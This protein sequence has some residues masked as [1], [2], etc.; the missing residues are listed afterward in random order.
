LEK[1]LAN[2]SF[3]IGRGRKKVRGILDAGYHLKIMIVFLDTLEDRKEVY[4][5]TWEVP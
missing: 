5:K 4:R 3:G 1:S 2:E